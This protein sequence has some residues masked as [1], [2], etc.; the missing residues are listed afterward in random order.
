MQIE[1]IG[2][3]DAFSE[4]Y[5]SS[6]FVIKAGEFR[7][8]VDCCERLRKALREARERGGNEILG[9]IDSILLTH[10]HGDHVGGL[11]AYAFYKFFV[12]RRKPHLY[13]ATPV[14]SELWEGRLKAPMRQLYNADF[15]Q[16]NLMTL[17]DYF[18]I[19]P[20]EPD[21]QEQVGPLQVEIFPTRHH[22]P[23][24]AA[25]FSYAGRKL[26]YSA[27]TTFDP[28]LLDF[29]APADLIIHE[30]GPGVHTPYEKLISLPPALT[31]KMRLI[32]YGDDF[33]KTTSRIKPLEEGEL[34][35]V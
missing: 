2:V 29:L 13:A 7:L 34:L 8:M 3:G 4:Q 30:V 16:L 27:D 28:A 20:L 11:E 9:Q 31:Q 22:I 18:E 5:N 32:H 35:E 15:S 1:V 12:D 14:L 19:H 17:E 25:R 6:S 10:L 26:A 24:F 33:D 23:T 21:R